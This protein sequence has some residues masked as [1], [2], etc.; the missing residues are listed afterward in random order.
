[1][2]INL[3]IKKAIDFFLEIFTVVYKRN[4]KNEIQNVYTN[5]KKFN[6]IIINFYIYLQCFYSHL[7]N[8][9][10]TK[11]EKKYIDNDKQNENFFASL[12]KKMKFDQESYTKKINE[13]LRKLKINDMDL[14]PKENIS[15]EEYKKFVKNVKEN[16]NNICHLENNLCNLDSFLKKPYQ[17]N[18]SELFHNIYIFLDMLSRYNNEKI[19]FFD[20]N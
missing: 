3:L 4:N 15:I 5:Q 11:H 9:D 17:N 14:L 20:E 16:R 7:L 19:N 10:K 13:F 2:N 1:M 12:I 6:L 18:L 8:E